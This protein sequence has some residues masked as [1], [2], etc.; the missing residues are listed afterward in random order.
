M[1]NYYI[2]FGWFPSDNQNYLFGKLLNSF[3]S[4]ADVEYSTKTMFPEK[5]NLFRAWNLCSFNKTKVVI[6]GQDPYHEKGQANGLAFAVNE[7]VKIPPS[8][9]NILKEIDNEYGSHKTSPDLLQWATQGVMLLN[10]YLCVEEGKT[11][12]AKRSGSAEV[13]EF[14]IRELS[15]DARPKVFILWG[16]E[17]QNLSPLIGEQ[18]LI[19]CSAHPSPLSANRGFFRNG[20]F[21]ATNEFLQ[22][23]GQKEIVW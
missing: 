3:L 2:P 7:G 15:A 9:R 14:T 12:T 10:R 19:L 6:I 11:L 17:A 1:G 23:T 18:H 16:K 22:R 5:N 20:H 8:L 21:R 13:V 4:W